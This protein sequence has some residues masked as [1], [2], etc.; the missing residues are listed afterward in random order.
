[1]PKRRPKEEAIQLI[2]EK[3]GEDAL[4]DIEVYVK[5][6]RTMINAICSTCG[7][8]ID[9]RLDILLRRDFPCNFCATKRH[10]HTQEEAE[11]LL[12]KHFGNKL[13]M[14]INTFTRVDKKPD[15]WCN[16]CGYHLNRRFRDI[17]QY[18][19]DNVCPICSN[20]KV[21]NADF[22][23]V[24]S[25]VINATEGTVDLIEE[26]FNGASK[27]SKAVCLVCGHEWF[28]KPTALYR[29]YRRCGK[30][31]GQYL[32]TY[33]EAKEEVDKKFNKSID[34]SEVEFKNMSSYLHF[35]CKRCG[36]VWV[37]TIH[38][39]LHTQGCLRCT[40]KNLESVVMNS[41]DK[42]EI[43][44]KHNK[45]LIGSNYNG[46]NRPLRGD[47]MFEHYPVLIEVDGAQHFFEVGGYA[48][49][50]ETQARDRHKDKYC[51]ENGICLIRITSS[52]TKE[53]GMKNHLTLEE[54]LALFDKGI[55]DGKVNM[56]LFWKYDFNRE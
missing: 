14:D 39:L 47:F 55:A 3:Y 50:I 41:L 16:D 19:V 48:N 1:M 15:I 49:F 33:Q 23:L 17:L 51:K 12:R 36:H 22:E 52:P 37:S 8:K 29:K 25:K 31:A 9:C 21:V 11:A 13:G 6:H 46:S 42:K 26:F 43:E 40:L 18:T 30:C 10:I 28:V 54:G 7:N 34:F 44:Y 38:G 27:L 24:R 53:W 35:H 5:D 32:H 2:K 45:G 4:T 56:N 20:K